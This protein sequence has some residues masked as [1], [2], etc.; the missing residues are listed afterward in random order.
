MISACCTGLIRSILVGN[1]EKN[2]PLGRSRFRLVDNT[3]GIFREIIFTM[4]IGF[5]HHE[6]GI[7]DGSF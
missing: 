1:L 7:S 5:I 6:L 2:G 3:K 4:W